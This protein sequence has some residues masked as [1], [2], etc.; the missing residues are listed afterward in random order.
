T[1]HYLPKV[2]EYVLV[3]PHH[4]IAPGSFRNSQEEP[5]GSNDMVHAYFLE[6]ARKM[7]QVKTRI[8]S[9]KDM[10]STRAHCTLNACT[11]KPRNIYRSSPV[12]KCSG[13]MSNDQSLKNKNNNPVEPKNHTHKPGRQ[14]GIG[15]KFSLNKSSAVHEKP[16]TPRSCL[17][18]KPT[19]R[20]FK[21]V[22]LRWIPTR[23]MFADST[24]VTP[25]KMGRSG[26]MSG[27]VT[28]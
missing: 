6:D 12:S 22:S 8:P 4:V 1:P 17:R 24:T 27:S 13:G 10:T 3:K 5:Y 18:W 9:H 28:S 15:Q 14:I 2:R 20:I 21:T 16:H 23:K 26:N 11:P 7:T 19:G 25:P